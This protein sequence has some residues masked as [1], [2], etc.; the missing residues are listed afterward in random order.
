MNLIATIC[1]LLVCI[2]VGMYSVKRFQSVSFRTYTWLSAFEMVKDS[3]VLGTGPGS[4]K[5]VYPSYRRP[6]IFYIENAHNTETQHAEN[7]YL[8]QAATGGV[9][10][11]AL[12]LWLM[13]FLFTCAF[14]NVHCTQAARSKLTADTERSFYLLGYASALA[15]LLIH[16]FVDISLHFASSGLLL[17][18]FIGV[19]LALSI[20][21]PVPPIV[22]ASPV[23][24]PGALW[25]ARGAVILA[26]LATIVYMGTEFIKVFR[27]LAVVTL[28]EGI[29]FALSVLIFVGCILAVAYLYG[30]IAWRS[31][32]IVVCALLLFSLPICISFFRIF[33]ANHYYSLG[34]A[35]VTRMQQPYA[36][37]PAFTDA[38]KRN[39]FLAEYRQYRANTFA[40]TLD[41]SK[42]FLP[43]L[44][45]TSSARTDYDRALQDFQFVQKHNPN[46]AMLH[47]DLGQLYY[48]LAM[49]Q[50]GQVQS[51]PGQ[52]FLYNQLAAE[53]FNRASQFLTYS[54]KLDP[55][56]INTY[57]ILIN[58]AL[59]QQDI[60][61]A[62]H[63]VDVYQRGP[64]GVTEEEFLQRHRNQSKI[65]A[66]Q[67]HLERLREA[68]NP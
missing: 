8:E 62:Q 59:F 24:H 18:V 44:G 38:I 21:H 22:E 57:L 39:P 19:I 55:V 65:Q 37:L 10:G 25:T 5:I 35:L 36:A 68:F 47:Q 34:V 66:V 64:E 46:H 52:A 12:F 48:A 51:D 50:L 1:L 13:V 30:K 60:N 43:D 32:R 63:W 6:Q 33:I 56:N 16:A 29:L 2:A 26:V 45:D 15:G 14:K 23:S 11:L 40:V 9:V 41:L 4:F 42:R 67:A 49:R 7:E 54:L 28:G 58:I 17:A 61:K 27:H 53:N 3:P 20:N 31:T